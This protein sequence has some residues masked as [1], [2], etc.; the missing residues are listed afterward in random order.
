MTTWTKIAK[1]IGTGW[2]PI[3]PSTKIV[4]DYALLQYNDMNTQYDGVG[5]AWTKVSKETGTSWTNIPK[6]T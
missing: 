2:Q 1:E 3:Y 5:G 6:A 4:Y